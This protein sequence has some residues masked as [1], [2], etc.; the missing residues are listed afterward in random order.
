VFVGPPDFG[1]AAGVSAP[2]TH[3]MLQLMRSAAAR[4]QRVDVSAMTNE[5]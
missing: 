1:R 3:H 4:A 2:A 5:R